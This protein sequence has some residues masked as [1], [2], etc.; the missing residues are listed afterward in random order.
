VRLVSVYFPEHDGR[1]VG[2]Y[3]RM[4]RALER[5]AAVNSPHTPLDVVRIT[6]DWSRLAERWRRGHDPQRESLLA[7]TAKLEAWGRAVESAAGGELIGLLDADLLVTGELAE[8]ELLS[9][10]LA[11][12]ERPAGARYPLN[13]G[14]VFLRVSDGTRSFMRRWVAT[15][16]RFPNSTL[17]VNPRK[18][19][20][21]TRAFRYT[22]PSP[23]TSTTIGSRWL[24]GRP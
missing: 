23:T 8:V 18:S 4:V 5:S 20:K 17:M 24:Q 3:G 1:S 14:V 19:A 7:N 15:S 10:D 16:V 13:G 6:P 2:V 21:T 9:F 12:T 11:Y 22:K